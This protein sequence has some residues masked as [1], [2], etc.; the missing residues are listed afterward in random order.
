MKNVSFTGV[1]LEA[2]YSKAPLPE[3]KELTNTLLNAISS[4]MKKCRL[5]KNTSDVF[6][7][8]NGIEVEAYDIIKQKSLFKSEKKELTAFVAHDNVTNK[9][10]ILSVTYD[11]ND[12]KVNNVL[13]EIIPHYASP[14]MQKDEK[15][16]TLGYLIS[17]KAINTIDSFKEEVQK[18]KKFLWDEIEWI[19]KS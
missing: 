19:G 10:E 6:E 5:A 16:T 7:Q 11:K 9:T 15:F 1:R 14:A 17:K 8:R 13:D 4:S 2:I 18:A 12:T 3:Q